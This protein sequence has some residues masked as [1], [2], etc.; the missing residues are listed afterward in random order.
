MGKGLR[1]LRGSHSVDLI[2]RTAGNSNWIV[3]KPFVTQA[4]NC[5]LPTYVIAASLE[6][7]APGVEDYCVLTYQAHVD[8]IT[9]L[10][11]TPNPTVFNGSIAAFQVP[12]YS[13]FDPATAPNNGEGF[14]KDLSVQ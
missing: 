12:G 14:D 6:A 9:E 7:G 1:W 8:P 2:D 11:Y 4:S 5:I 10:P 13:G 3:V